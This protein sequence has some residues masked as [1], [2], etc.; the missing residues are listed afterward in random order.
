M[1]G[2]KMAPMKERCLI[3]KWP[4]SSASLIA[5]GTQGHAGPEQAESSS[6][7]TGKRATVSSLLCQYLM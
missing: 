3:P 7:E 2:R 6:W 4:F 1:K 5:T